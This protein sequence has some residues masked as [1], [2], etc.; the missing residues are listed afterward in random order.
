MRFKENK[1][2]TPKDDEEDD[3]NDKNNKLPQYTCD[4]K[5]E[6]KPKIET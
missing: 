4:D 3:E 5:Y 1:S 6:E 2:K